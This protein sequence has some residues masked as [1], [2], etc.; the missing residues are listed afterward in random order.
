MNC[1]STSELFQALDGRLLSVLSSYWRIE[2]YGVFEQDGSCWVQLALRGTPDHN[3]AMRVG[4]RE[5]D[6]EVLD[7]LSLW[8][9]DP[10]KPGGRVLSFG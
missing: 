9:A 1:L 8:L 7:A 5:T 3:V 10:S 2:I 6:T 4:P